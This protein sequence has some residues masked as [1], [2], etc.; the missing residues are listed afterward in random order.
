MGKYFCYCRKSQEYYNWVVWLFGLKKQGMK[1]WVIHSS[2]ID[3]KSCY[4]K[5]MESSKKV[6]GC[7]FGDCRHFFLKD[8]SSAFSYSHLLS[9]P[10]SEYI[11]AKKNCSYNLDYQPIILTRTRCSLNPDIST[12]LFIFTIF[13]K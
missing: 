12:N 5:L 11:C 4:K 9:R 7:N 10:L 1:L 13:R 2:T 6:C 8:N 3:T